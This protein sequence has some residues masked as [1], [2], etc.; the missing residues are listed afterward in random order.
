MEHKRNYKLRL[1]I[2][3]LAGV[4]VFCIVDT[5]RQHKKIHGNFE[6]AATKAGQ[7]PGGNPN[8]N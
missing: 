8:V 6:A 1:L 7:R 5:R 3:H 2:D 4:F